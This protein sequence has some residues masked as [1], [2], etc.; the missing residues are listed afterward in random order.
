V[1]D[2]LPEEFAPKGPKLSRFPIQPPPPLRP[3]LFPDEA[4]FVFRLAVLVGGTE[5]AAWM[6]LLGFAGDRAVL[7]VGALRLLSP[8]W[9]RLGTRISR[10]AIAFT[11][12]F[13]A[14]VSP[15][16][17]LFASS[18]AISGDVIVSTNWYRLAS[19]AIACIALPALG[20]LCATCVGDSITVERRAAAYSWLDMAHAL[21][22][23]LAFVAQGASSLVFERGPIA[24]MAFLMAPLLI[25]SI[26]VPDLRDRGTPRSSW[27]LTAYAS[28][29][30]TPVSAQVTALAFICAVFARVER[31]A[32]FVTLPAA[33][34]WLVFVLPLAGMAVAARLESRMPNAIWLPRIAVVLALIA[35]IL[36][37]RAIA[38]FALGMMISA[39]PAAVARGAAE[40]ERPLASSLAWMGLAAGAAIGAML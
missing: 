14:L 17:A 4:R 7:F 8:L 2:D 12:L 26:G 37:S 13:A 36:P 16:A 9:A 25:A 33:P 11:L 6:W 22:V 30:R 31:H 32:E 27:P 40:I 29:L 10:P 18:Q 5:L 21:G 23:A 28:T 19:F 15:G 35:W 39:I 34:Q 24:V 20:D 38:S 3:R 1:P